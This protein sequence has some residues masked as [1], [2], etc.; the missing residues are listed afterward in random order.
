[1]PRQSSRQLAGSWRA[2]GRQAE[3]VVGFRLLVG[4][5]GMG[6]S[7]LLKVPGIYLSLVYGYIQAVYRI[8][9][10]STPILNGT[11]TNLLL[12]T[13]RPSLSSLTPPYCSASSSSSSHPFYSLS[14]TPK[15]NQPP[16]PNP[17]PPP[18]PNPHTQTVSTIYPATS[19]PAAHNP[20]PTPTPDHLYSKVPKIK[21][22]LR[23]RQCRHARGKRKIAPGAS[24]KA[25]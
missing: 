18:S 25:I 13:F 2:V 22:L 23:Q 19:A 12:H 5:C 1:M 4:R 20:T 6:V 17:Q 14:R 21:V 9:S 10:H 3:T 7:C 16:T 8:L 24:T 11:Q 15:I